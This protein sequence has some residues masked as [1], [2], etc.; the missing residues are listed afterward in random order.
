M[1]IFREIKD[2]KGEYE[3]SN[4]G[5]VKSLKNNIIL[6]QRINKK[7][8]LS[9]GLWKN[10]K[11]YLK[12]THRIVAEAFLPNPLGL[13]CV[14]HKNE[15]KTD[16]RVWVN[17]DGSVDLEKSNLEWC[18]YKYNSN[19]GTCIERSATKRRGQKRTEET[20]AKMRGISKPKVAEALRGKKQ[21][22]ETIEKRVKKLSKP[23]VAVDMNGNVV[24][25]FPSKNEAGRNGFTESAV[26]TACNNHYARKGNRFYKGYYW[27]F[28][29]DWEEIQ[30][31]SPHKREDA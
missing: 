11:R 10:G 7:G 4:Y 21:P 27:Y 14:N 15:I 29:E 1:E 3:I 2:F 23:V 20:K 19:Y 13:P 30:K 18:T 5:N 12:K 9:V 26:S 8:Y 22:K 31:A 6:K 25:E 24:Y 17:E 16:N 28:K